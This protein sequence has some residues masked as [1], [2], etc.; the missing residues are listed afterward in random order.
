MPQRTR[1]VRIEKPLIPL[2]EKLVATEKD[3]FGRKKYRSL[4]HIITVAVE[5][6]LREHQD[7]WKQR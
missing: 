1:T 6:F 4:T 5:E 2:L 3:E 7:A